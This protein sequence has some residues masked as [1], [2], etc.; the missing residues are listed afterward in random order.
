M[1]R[2]LV[3]AVLC[4]FWHEAKRLRSRHTNVSNVVDGLSGASDIAE[5]FAAK[6]STLYTSVSYNAE[7]IDV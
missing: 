7:E 3:Y 1:S 5:S 2:F 4:D 6:Y